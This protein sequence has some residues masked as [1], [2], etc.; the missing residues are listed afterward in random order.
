MS[1]RKQAFEEI[2]T[3]RHVF[4]DTSHH[5]F[6]LVGSPHLAGVEAHL[7]LALDGGVPVVLHRVV[8]PVTTN[9]TWI[10]GSF[11]TQKSAGV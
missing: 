2:F 10:L 7:Q 9:T 1:Y 6:Q 3:H 8:R 5:V 11:Q 4:T